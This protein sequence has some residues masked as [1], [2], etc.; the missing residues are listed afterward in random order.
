MALL[1][2]LLVLLSA[3]AALLTSNGAGATPLPGSSSNNSGT[4]KATCINGPPATGSSPGSLPIADYSLVAP[5]ANLNW[6]SYT[7]KQ[8]WWDKHY[9]SGP[10]VSL[11]F[12][13]HFTSLSRLLA[14]GWEAGALMGSW[15]V[16]ERSGQWNGLELGN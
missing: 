10:H 2:N 7:V 4:K 16:T 15:K 9:L 11:S 3:T 6:T 13:F 14:K 12:H 1:N 8:S 5:A